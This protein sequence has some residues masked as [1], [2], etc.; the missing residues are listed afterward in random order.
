MRETNARGMPPICP[1]VRHFEPE[2]V[3]EPFRA[4]NWFFREVCDKMNHRRPADRF[5]P[6]GPG[7]LS[8]PLLLQPRRNFSKT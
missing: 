5:S 3:F 2:E 1:V 8:Q 4:A 6:G 7:A